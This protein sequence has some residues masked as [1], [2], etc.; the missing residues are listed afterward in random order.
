MKQPTAAQRELSGEEAKGGNKNLNIRL[1]F[2]AYSERE[3][4]LLNLHWVPVNFLE[5]Y[6]IQKTHFPEHKVK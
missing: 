6:Y 1:N 2:L 4:K 5:A 3:V